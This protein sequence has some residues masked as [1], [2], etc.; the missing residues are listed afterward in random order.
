MDH[1]EHPAWPRRRVL[2]L[3]PIGIVVVMTGCGG[4]SDSTTP[5]PSTATPL[6]TPTLTFTID[7]AADHYLYSR[8]LARMTPG[9]TFDIA[10]RLLAINH[11]DTE[12]FAHAVS[13]WLFR[14]NTEP[15]ATSEDGI[16]LSF[17][18]T[19]DSLCLIRLRTPPDIG[20]ADTGRSAD[21]RIGDQ[22]RF[23]VSCGA[24]GALSFSLEGT[25]LLTLP[26]TVE[27]KYVFT[28]VVGTKAAFEYVPI[29]TTPTGPTGTGRSTARPCGPCPVL[30]LP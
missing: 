6:P 2:R 7:A 13:F 4:G 18:W 16:A 5:T 25:N 11:G 27:A 17:I 23:R 26:S 29:G 15:E 21:I 14:T 28:R 19:S 1:T 30:A 24:D 12:G 8:S 20:Y 9:I 22:R 3:G 10:F